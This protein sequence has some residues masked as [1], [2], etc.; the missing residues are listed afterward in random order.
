MQSV[1]IGSNS[2]L[3]TRILHLHRSGPRVLDVTFG[4]GRFWGRDS[5]VGPGQENYRVVGLDLPMGTFADRELLARFPQ[6]EGVVEGGY[7][8]LRVASGMFDVVI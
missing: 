8:A 5:L 4:H 2:E 6:V 1:F 7:T 3:V